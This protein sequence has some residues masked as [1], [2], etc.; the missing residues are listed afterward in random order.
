MSLPG[1]LPTAKPTMP[2]VWLGLGSICLATIAKLYLIGAGPDLEEDAYGHALAA[3]LLTQNPT[4]LQVHWV[5]LPLGHVVSAVLL[6]LGFGMDGMRYLNSALT[7]FLALGIACSVDSIGKSSRGFG[8]QAFRWTAAAVVALSPLALS[9][10]ESGALEPLFAVMVLAS[11]WAVRSGHGVLAGMVASCAVLLRYEGWLLPPVFFWVWWRSG[12]AGTKAWAWLAPL[13]TICAYVGV[14]ASVDGGALSF[15]RENDEF[16]RS[17]FAGVAADWPVSPHPS[18]MAIWYAVIVPAV[19][20]GPLMPFAV[21]GAAWLIRSGPRPLTGALLAILGFL[22]LGFVARQH[23]GLPRHAL[24]LT[25][26]YAMAATAGL[27]GAAT[28]LHHRL[29]VRRVDLERWT[30]G[31]ATLAVIAFAASRTLPTFLGRST[32]HQQ[33]HRDDL[34]IAN[35]LQSAWSKRAR[36]FC[37]VT[38]V[39]T[40]SDLPPQSF[41]RWQ[42]PD[43][44][45]ANLE[46]EH[47][48]GRDVLVVGTQARASHLRTSLHAL[49]T[50][51][52][53]VLYRYVSSG[54]VVADRANIGNSSLTRPQRRTYPLS[55]L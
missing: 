39:E 42:L 2:W 36:I 37:D 38:A 18:W 25:P 31:F 47:A 26:I 24:T 53:L 6:S 13:V 28:W 12:R 41:V 46:L 21:A 14:R 10:G 34:V 44:P 1:P 35:A 22:T 8:T 16:A 11:A 43:T 23:L 48:A 17:F 49:H 3:R 40:L 52:K 5:W 27:L 30:F 29:E 54:D 33:L 9:T 55:G 7:S 20:L 4:D 15:L 19:V 45:V 32:L 51:G 50:A